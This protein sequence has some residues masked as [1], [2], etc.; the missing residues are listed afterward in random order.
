MQR[1]RTSVIH[2][3]DPFVMYD[4]AALLC[5]SDVATSVLK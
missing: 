3:V 2:D 1:Q 5:V 4:R